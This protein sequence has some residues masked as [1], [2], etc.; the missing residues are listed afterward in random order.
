MESWQIEL[1][2]IG[3]TA[4]VAFLL[5]LGS[6]WLRQRRREKER[7]AQFEEYLKKREIEKA[8]E[9]E[10]LQETEKLT[11]LFIEHRRHKISPEAFG[12]FRERILSQASQ[13][14]L[15]ARS[16]EEISEVEEELYEKAWYD[17]HKMLESAVESGRS[18]VD[19]EIWEKALKAAKEVEKK[20]GKNQLGPYSD[21]EWGMLLGK[22]SSLRWVLGDEWDNCD[23]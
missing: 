3:A 14:E 22:L 18:E 21:F 15:E 1:L 5:G 8:P 23:T 9:Q 20:Y 13:D 11:T 6:H 19:P 7:D 12:E 4:I 16:L 2:K 10:K 17:R